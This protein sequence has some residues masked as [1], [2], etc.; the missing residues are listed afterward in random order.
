MRSFLV[1]IFSTFLLAQAHAQD[2]VVV[3]GANNSNDV[4]VTEITALQPN[5]RVVS[6]PNVQ[7]A[8]GLIEVG[9]KI[10]AIV[11]VGSSLQELSKSSNFPG[12]NGAKAG[13]AIAQGFS[14]K[15]ISS[16]LTVYFWNCTGSCRELKG[17]KF[18]EDFREAFT[19]ILKNDHPEL[20]VV[21]KS[22]LGETTS[23]GRRVVEIVVSGL[24]VAAMGL[25]YGYRGIIKI[26]S[27]PIRGFK[28]VAGSFKSSLRYLA[29]INFMAVSFTFDN[30]VHM[31]T[32][33]GISALWLGAVSY[34][35]LRDSVV[36]WRTLHPNELPARISCGKLLL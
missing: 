4:S 9:E 12:S 7:T 31:Y 16:D 25:G 10:A 8:Q 36:H 22:R 15:N 30:P 11:M 26:G 24:R 1:S 32:G 21:L 27:L 17:V 20:D 33:V 14:S 34:K 29:P 19:A 28:R 23:K 18:Q 3:L 5:A 6:A 2:V 35:P 13:V